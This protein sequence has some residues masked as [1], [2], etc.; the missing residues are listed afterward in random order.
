M[1]DTVVDLGLND[2]AVYGL[3]P[4]VFEDLVARRLGRGGSIAGLGT[5]ELAAL[6]RE[7]LARYRELR[8]E[9][10]PQDPMQQ[11]ERA[12]VAVFHSW[13]SERARSYRQLR[14]LEHLEGTAL[15]VQQMVFGN[16][17][18]RSG[19]GVLFT[20]DPATGERRLYLDFLFDAQGEDVV[21]GRR[22]VADPA[23]FAALLPAA[24]TELESIARRVERELADLQDL[25]FT[26]EEGQLFL[27]QSRA[28]KRTPWAALR[29]AVDLVDEGVISPRE[30]LA[31]L[32]ELDLAGL[33]RTALQAG[34]EP[35]AARAIPA[36]LGIA[37]GRAVFESGR[38]EALVASGEPVILVRES[39]ETDD[40]PGLAVA[41]GVLTA[42]GGR[43]SHAAVVAR[44]LGRVCLVGCVELEVEPA[45]RR[46]KLAGRLLDEGDFL[47][48]D[49]ERGEIFIGRREV[50]RER[51]EALLARL[52]S[53]QQESAATD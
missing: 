52:R 11:L 12:A 10:F 43:T 42:S 15:V 36:G 6:A 49:G 45:A 21:S 41:Q 40:L 31:R 1:L 35:P 7:S 14:G 32:A 53:W 39:I 3:P 19:S 50:I 34:G 29:V 4:A 37:V 8:G 25:E 16:A 17:G 33:E 18:P 9:P 47:S 44:E 24:A 28:G 51:P 30:A 23:D 2:E 38:A 27:L 46:A 22:R 48:L 13:R 20:R 5:D 26:I